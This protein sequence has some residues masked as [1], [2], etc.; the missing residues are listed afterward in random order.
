MDTLRLP[1]EY[2]VLAPDG[3]EIRELVSVNGGS[4]AHCRL[5]RGA[6]SMAVKH[7]AVEEVWYFIQ[8]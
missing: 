8:G 7:R 6:T 4:M 2:T 3:S 1:H 5:P